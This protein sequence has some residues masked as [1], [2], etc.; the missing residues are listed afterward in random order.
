MDNFDV[1][2]IGSGVGGLC[3]GGLLAS[4]GKKG[5]IC[6][7]H[8]QPGGVAHSFSR[9]DYK[10]ESGPSLPSDIGTDRPL[11]RET[12]L[13]NPGKVDIVEEQG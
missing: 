1:V 5:L 10:F 11:A 3:C 2:I 8:S 13:L 6:E 4:R 9:N 7:S 12:G